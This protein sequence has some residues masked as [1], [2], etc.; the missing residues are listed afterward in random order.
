MVFLSDN[1]KMCRRA[2]CKQNFYQIYDEMTVHTKCSAAIRDRLTML[3]L[4]K[5]CGDGY[6]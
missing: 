1:E 6:I 3:L 5:R 2:H 4:S